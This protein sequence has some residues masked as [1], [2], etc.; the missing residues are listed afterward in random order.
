MKRLVY[1]CVFSVAALSFSGCLKDDCQATRTFYIWE[2]VYVKPEAFRTELA[3]VGVRPLKNPGKIYYY[4]NYILI[5]ELRE[6]VHIFDNKDPKHPTAVAFLPIPGNVDMA[7][8]DN[9]LYADSYVDLLAIDISTPN[10]PALKSR[11]ENVFQLYGFDERLG[12]IVHYVETEQTTDIDC[13]NPNFGNP[14]WLFDSFGRVA[15]E[16]NASPNNST[17]A[18]ASSSGVAGSLARF[19]ISSGYLYAIDQS[20]LKIFDIAVADRPKMANDVYVGWGI[21]TL[22]P[23]KE[24][25]FIGA[26]DGM[27]IFNNTTPTKPWH[28]SKFEHARACDPVFV[29][30]NTAYVTLRDGTECQDFGNQLDVVDISDLFGPKLLASYDL[31]HPFGLSKAG[32]FLYICEDDQGLKVFDASEWSKIGERLVEQVKGFTTY[33]VIILESQNLAMVVGKDGFYQ[34]D[35]QNP[36]DLKQ[37]SH[38]PVE[39]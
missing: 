2:P 12:Y 5:N 25:L 23:Y 38:I 26:N 20:N 35:I 13:S 1:L 17:S 34:F 31:H 29:D 18:A 11:A 8:R 30:E 10:A 6:G 33:D 36:K 4:E 22:F 39:K 21:E 28:V 15:A 37:I 9:I 27:Y 7:I 16:S 19:G 3:A 24:Y 14:I 32:N